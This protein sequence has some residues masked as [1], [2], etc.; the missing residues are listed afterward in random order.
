M[1]L[2]AFTKL[3]TF[4]RLQLEHHD[5]LTVDKARHQDIRELHIGLLNMMPDASLQATERQFMRLV[6]DCNQIVQ[7]YVHLFTIPDIKRSSS[8][9]EWIDEYYEDFESIETHGLDALIISGAN[10]I[11]NELSEE[12]FW[13]GLTEVIDWAKENVTSVL[14]ACLATHAV[15]QYLYDIKRTPLSE[16]KW[17]VFEH[18]LTNKQHPLVRHMNT[19]FDV[20]HSRYNQLTS[21]QIKEKGLIPLALSEQAELHLAV[22]PDGFR[23]VFFQ[24]HP[25]YDDLSLFKE[26]QREVN[27]WFEN[28]RQD[29]PPFPKN[30]FNGELQELL[31]NF[32]EKVTQAKSNKRA[33]P[34]WKNKLIYPQLDNTWRDT[35]L[36]IYNNWL[37]LVYRL[38]DKNPKK[39]FMQGV[40]PENPLDSI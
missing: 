10:P 39:L 31:L 14:C 23:F 30:Y 35:A 29:Y 27:R 6:G 28:K 21:D 17:G 40:D 12:V 2:V 25:E 19:R 3:P 36:S 4:E 8:T 5:V 18:R 11:S 15:V 1:P 22:S 34:S 38:T 32:K 33:F 26:Y 7:F 16:K 37:G 24:G 9:Q 13:P 20:P